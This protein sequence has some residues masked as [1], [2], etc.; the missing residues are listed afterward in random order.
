M[1][2]R[3]KDI[4]KEER[5][6]ERLKEVGI[7]NISNK[8]LIS[9]ILKTGTKNKNVNEISLEILNKYNL[10]QLKDLSLNDLMSID[11][12]GEVLKQRKNKKELIYGR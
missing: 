2:Y 10:S 4:P 3:I 12:V 7:E 8:E 6:R 5:P 1:N 11:G 9:I